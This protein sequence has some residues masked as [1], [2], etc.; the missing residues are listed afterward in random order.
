MEVGSRRGTILYKTH[1]LP[2]EPASLIRIVSAV[3]TVFLLTKFDCT[4]KDNR[5]SLTLWGLDS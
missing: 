5:F 2:R 1:T 4:L 3:H